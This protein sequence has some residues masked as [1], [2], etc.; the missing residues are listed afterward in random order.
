MPS[1]QFQVD[2]Q[3]FYSLLLPHLLLNSQMDMDNQEGI[4]EFG[5]V[6]EERREA[7][8]GESELMKKSDFFSFFCFLLKL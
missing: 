7:Q 3:L 5:E 2:M 4:V 8:I 1:S 6:E